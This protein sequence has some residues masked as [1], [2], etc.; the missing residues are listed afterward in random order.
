MIHYDENG[1]WMDLSS[2]ELAMWFSRLR[3]AAQYCH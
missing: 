1:V 3:D 2:H